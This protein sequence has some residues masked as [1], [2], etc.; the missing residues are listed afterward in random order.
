MSE[1]IRK[2]HK[3]AIMIFSYISLCIKY[4]IKIL[5]FVKMQYSDYLESSENNIYIEA[6]QIS[7]S[8]EKFTFLYISNF[9]E[10]Y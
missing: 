7:N 6:W 5:E 10:N 8:G 1:N 3:L 9:I 2:L 4:A